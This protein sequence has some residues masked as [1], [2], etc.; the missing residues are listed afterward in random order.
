MFEQLQNKIDA[1]LVGKINLEDPMFVIVALG[2][3]G[4]VLM[5]LLLK[6]SFISMRHADQKRKDHLQAEFDADR[7]D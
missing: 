2:F 6:A 5:A 1:N 3:C 4:V 7:S